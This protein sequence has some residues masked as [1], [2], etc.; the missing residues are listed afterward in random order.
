MSWLK[1]S[2]GGIGVMVNSVVVVQVQVVEGGLPCRQQQRRPSIGHI[3]LAQG[4]WH[5][6]CKVTRHYFRIEGDC[7]LNS[8]SCL[9]QV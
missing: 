8:I 7:D 5:S 1:I 6:L 9:K 3:S 4:T 2:R